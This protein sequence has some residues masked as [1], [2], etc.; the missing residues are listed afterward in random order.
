MR[1]LV[2]MPVVLVALIAACGVPESGEFES[3]ERE[4]VPF[5]LSA[6]TVPTTSLAPTTTVDATTTTALATSTTI[7]TELVDLYL[8]AGSQ[9]TSI[10]IQLPSPVSLQQT[11]AALLEG[12]PEGD[13]GRGLRSAIPDGAEI[14]VTLDS[15]SA[16][17]DLPS[18][19]FDTMPTRDQRLLFAQIVLTIGNARRVG[20]VVF[21]MNAEPYS[22]LRGDGSTTAPGEAVTI[23][24]YTVLLSG[25]PS[26][27]TTTVPT[28]AA[29]DGTDTAGSDP[30]GG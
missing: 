17:V 4:D 3:I 11:M 25:T 29:P 7:S 10:S 21:T 16:V 22:A 26:L 1:R 5:D 27:D 6:T 20:Q 30:E 23:D 28:S 8:V 24:D 9:L 2:V 12:P 13:L 19:I 14:T 18:D 15:P